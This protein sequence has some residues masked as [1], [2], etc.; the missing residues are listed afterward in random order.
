MKL[1]IYRRDDRKW[2]WRLLTKNGSVVATDGGQGYERRVD[3]ERQ[4]RIVLA[5]GARE[6]FNTIDI[7]YV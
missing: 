2:A 7:V 6:A 3:C 1:E 5:I 4:A